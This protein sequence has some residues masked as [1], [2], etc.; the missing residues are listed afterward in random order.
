MGF[1]LEASDTEAGPFLRR[2]AVE[3]LDK[4][5]ADLEVARTGDPRTGVHGVRK[6][7]KKLRGLVRLVRG[8]FDGYGRINATLRDTARVLSEARDRA[9][10]I[11]ALDR[12]LASEAA[13][14]IDGRRVAP[15]LRGLEVE[16]DRAEAAR[17]LGDRLTVVASALKA[18]R[19]EAPDWT[20]EAA[21]WD[22]FEGGLTKTY[23]RARKGMT[24]ARDAPCMETL[25]G[26]RKRAKYHGHH[27]RLLEPVWPAGMAGHAAEA[28]GLSDILGDRH[29]LDVLEP[30][31]AEA[32]IHGDTLLALREVIAAERARL[33][34][35]AQLAGGRLLADKPRT[36]ARRWGCWYALR[37]QA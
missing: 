13:A 22:A 7:I 18:L 14:R 6:R 4:G 29:D 3:Q 17:D 19:A 23:A 8:G 30:R 36:L 10:L 12:L 15:L 28:S 5:L 16:R 25:H 1:A 31:V 32:D 2:V 37:D 20:L 34:A 26:W 24:T 35:L 27:A 9:A 33:D 21:G 11:E